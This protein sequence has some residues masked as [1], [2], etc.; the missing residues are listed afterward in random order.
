MTL[1][2]KRQQTTQPKVVRIIARLNVGGPAR[3]A[4]MLHERLAADFET[5]LVTGRLDKG[6]QDMSY[7]LSSARDV[8]RLAEMSRKVS[9]WSDLK[10]FWKIFRILRQEQPQIVHTHT[11]KAGA[12]GR[13]AAWL[14]GVPVIVH[15]YHGHVFEG[16]FSPLKSKL[17]LAIERM[18][19]RLCTR[20]IAISESQKQEFVAKY[21][22]VPED[23]L[24]VVQNGFEL[25]DYCLANRQQ[26]RSE[27]GLAAD[28]FVVAWAGRMV[29][30]KDISL[31][32]AVVKKASRSGKKMSFLIVGSGVQ[33]AKLEQLLQSCTNVKFLGWREDMLQIWAAADVALLTSRA[34]GTPT[35]LIEAMAAGRPFVATRVGAV[36][37]L[38][39][40]HLTDLPNG[41]GQ[42]AA[43]GFLAQRSADAL[44]ACLKELAENPKNAEE[45]GAV[46]RAFALE[47]F[48][49][50]RLVEEMKLLYQLLLAEQT[51]QTSKAVPRR[52]GSGTTLQDLQAQVLP[53]R[54]D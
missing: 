12:L 40:G 22:V 52:E 48:T 3:Q 24:S 7:L 23:K 42:R 1:Q 29:P 4:C 21:R 31:L 16:Y 45:M 14:A 51:L 34:E 15:T 41:A 26:A 39:V 18:L 8:L 11:A 54:R 44:F 49:A 37:D 50:D 38:A 19:G 5:R 6:E 27:L 28:D 47:H 9:L 13:V 2:T 43:N 46:A 33:K 10:A 17:C 30:I 32:A 25:K 36:P 35:A 20:V 53:P